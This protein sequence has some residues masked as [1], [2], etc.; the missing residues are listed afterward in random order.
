MVTKLDRAVLRYLLALNLKPTGRDESAL[1]EYLD[2]I[3]RARFD[4]LDQLIKK[5]RYRGCHARPAWKRRDN[6]HRPPLA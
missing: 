4:V 2:R 6:P 5:P 1:A 3:D